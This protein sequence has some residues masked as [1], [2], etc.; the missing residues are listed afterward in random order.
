MYGNSLL[1][2]DPMKQAYVGNATIKT[3]CGK[4]DT[5][6]WDAPIVEEIYVIDTRTIRDR[7][8]QPTKVNCS[9]GIVVDFE[10]R[11]VVWRDPN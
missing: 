6:V 10:W 3:V 11:E 8:T 9:R 1:R 2:W 7:W 5:R 4:F